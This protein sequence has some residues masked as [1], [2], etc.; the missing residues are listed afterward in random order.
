[1]NNH[2]A[3]L[4]IYVVL[5][6]ATLVAIFFVGPAAFNQRGNYWLGAGLVLACM[7]FPIAIYLCRPSVR[8]SFAAIFA[9]RRGNRALNAG[10]FEVATA[11]YCKALAIAETMQAN[12]D[13]F[14]GSALMGIAEVDRLRGRLADAEPILQRAIMHFKEARPPRFTELACARQNLAAVYINQGRFRDAE[15]LCRQSLEYFENVLGRRAAYAGVA[16]LNL[17]QIMIGLNRLDD[18]ETVTAKGSN[19]LARLI[20][21][22]DLIGGYCLFA[23]S[24]LALRRKRLAEAEEPAC[25]AVAILDKNSGQHPIHGRALCNLGEIL[26]QQNRLDESE[27]LCQRACSLLE[28]SLGP[29][30]YGLDRGLATLARI[31]IAQG[32][33][34]DAEQLLRRCL[35]ILN[36]V[37]VPEHPDRLERMTELAALLR[38]M[39][40]DSEANRIEA[41]FNAIPLWCEPG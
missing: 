10:N 27:E 21:R 16:Y 18:A 40:R 28:N 8:K 5:I 1:M 39:K 23:L 37:V 13:S 29:D 2:K 36:P 20:D 41:E 9:I 19:L 31:R 26:R 14:M 34:A 12:H 7:A 6:A 11:H 3:P 4:A 15:P 25:R 33:M 17:G 38:V 22:G 24:D 35:R 30:Y 32:K